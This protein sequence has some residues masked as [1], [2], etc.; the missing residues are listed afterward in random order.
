[1][2]RS[3]SQLAKEGGAPGARPVAAGWRSAAQGDRLRPRQGGCG[4]EARR[5]R[6][7]RRHPRRQRGPARDG[8]ARELQL[9]R[10]QS[11]AAGQLR[12]PD[13]DGA[14]A[15]PS[16]PSAARVTW[17]SSRPSRARSAHRAHRSTTRR[18][19]AFGDSRLGSRG[20]ASARRR[21]L[22]RLAGLRARGRD[23]R[24]LRHQAGTRTGHDHAEKGREGGHPRD[25][26][27][28]AARSRS[29]RRQRFPT[30]IGY[31]HPEFAGRMQRRGGADRI[32]MLAEGQVTS[33]D[34]HQVAERSDAADGA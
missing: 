23:V 31:R 17:S 7:Q 6:R 33:A 20:S 13:R 26:R 1:M 15:R 28:R 8:E 29:H 24:R 25:R 5:G 2:G 12:I 32:A 4:R 11:G 22:D 3:S 27:N 18:S 10:A 16:S 21:R 34:G 14:G 19:L 9:E 30:E